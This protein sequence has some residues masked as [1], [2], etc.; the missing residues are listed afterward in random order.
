FA[1]TVKVQSLKGAAVGA[2]WDKIKRWFWCS[3]V[4]QRYE[5]PQNTLN[6]ADVRQLSAWIDDDSK[7]PE[8]VANFSLGDLELAGVQR[9]RNAVYRSV[10]SLTIVNGAR[11][12][13]TGNR[14]TADFLS[15]PQRKIEDHHI[16]ATAYLKKKQG[17]SGENSILNRCLIDN[18]TNKI[19]SDKAPSTY[20]TE[21][22]THL[23]AER[24]E[25]V[26]SSHLIPTG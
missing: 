1:V 8:A 6:S 25:D 9:Q 10:I 3:C 4:G 24:L 5:G 11:D 13:H 18:V 20:L 22:E 14:L 16:F 12:F 26:L 17:R 21:V 23:G 7:V 19:I 15:D 2:A